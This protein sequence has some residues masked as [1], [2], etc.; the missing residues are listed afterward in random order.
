MKKRIIGILL[1]AFMLIG[2]IPFSAISVFAE[3]GEIEYLKLHDT[4]YGLEIGEYDT[5]SYYYVDSDITCTADEAGVSGIS[6]P[7]WSEVHIFVEKGVTL[8]CKG[9]DATLEVGGGA[10]IEVP[11][12]AKLYLEG[13]GTVIATG[14]KAADGANG[15]YGGGGSFYSE[16]VFFMVFHDYCYG[17]NGGNGGHGGGG[18][19]AGIGTAG[20]AGS[21]GGAGGK[22]DGGDADEDHLNVTEGE[23]GLNGVTA[24]PVGTVRTSPTVKLTTTGGA[25]GNGGT[26]KFNEFLIR[27]VTGANSTGV[28]GCPGGGGQGGGAGASVGTGGRGGGGGAGGNGSPAIYNSGDGFYG[29]KLYFGYG[30]GNTD[31][32]YVE[33]SNMGQGGDEYILRVYNDGGLMPNYPYPVRNFGGAGGTDGVEHT[34]TFDEDDCCIVCAKPVFLIEDGV[35][36]EYNGFGGNLIIPDGVTKIADNVFAENKTV[37]GIVFPATLEEIG[38]SAFQGTL[39]TSIDIPASVKAIGYNA[40]QN[41]TNLQNVTVH[42]T[43]ADEIVTPQ[44]SAFTGIA[45]DCVLSVP[46]NTAQL[47]KNNTV[48]SKFSLINDTMLYMAYDTELK[49]FV[50]QASPVAP[51]EL[52]SSDD[53]VT[54][55]GG[56]YVAGDATIGGSLTFE[57]DAFIILESGATLTVNGGIIAGGDLTFYAQTTTLDDMGGV[58]VPGTAGDG[59]SGIN[60]SGKALNIHG[61]KIEVYGGRY[62]AGIGGVERADGGNVTVY[63]GYVK[64]QSKADGAG[65]GGGNGGAGGKFTIYGGKVVANGSN[66]SGIGGGRS[67]AGGEIVINGGEVETNGNIGGGYEHGS[68]GVTTKVTINDCKITVSCDYSVIGGSNSTVEINGG[69]IKTVYGAIGVGNGGSNAVVTIR[70][71]IIDAWNYYYPAIGGSD[72]E[73]YVNIY[74]GNIKAKSSSKDAIVAT[75]VNICPDDEKCEQFTVKDF[76]DNELTDAPITEK[77]V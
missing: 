54:L 73:V 75:E 43:E 47:Y 15:D 71:G 61:G 11:E 46:S 32:N 30:G 37:T 41:C 59:I 68:L 14:G 48:W 12:H 18:A 39:L 26:S 65:I 76:S 31:G 63:D 66:S 53:A 38:D 6:I 19:G 52:T 21:K 8:T 74:G 7:D 64:A 42:W 77:T 24:N 51:T 22:G 28:P 35:L 60:C 1:T 36:L 27:L 20:G 62:A 3:T 72:D 45:S 25:R 40:F 58:H 23:R 4:Q 33:G 5:V 16:E 29:A 50:Q 70:G 57:G 69:E 2:I 56:W 9:G 34:H 55:P 17:G 49:T 10:G 67:G 13:E 44:G